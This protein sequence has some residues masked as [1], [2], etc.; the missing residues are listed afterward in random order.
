MV[1]I[2]GAIILLD[3]MGQ[4]ENCINVLNFIN[5]CS[6]NWKCDFASS[7]IKILVHY[8]FSKCNKLIKTVWKI[9]TEQEECTG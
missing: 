4:I 7:I 3:K 6:F 8:I 9:L 1:V 2:N 5:A